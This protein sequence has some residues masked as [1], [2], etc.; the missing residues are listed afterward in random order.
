MVVARFGEGSDADLEEVVRYV[1]E[2]VEGMR[3]VPKVTEKVVYVSTGGS[4]SRQTS[5]YTAFGKIQKDGDVENKA[6]L[7]EL[8]GA[9]RIRDDLE[10]AAKTTE[11]LS[12]LADDRRESLFGEYDKVSDA[13]KAAKD[14]GL[15]GFA[16]T[17]FVWRNL[18]EAQKKAVE[19]WR[20]ESDA[21]KMP[22]GV[23]PASSM[24][25][26]GG[27]S[28][29]PMGVPLVPT[30]SSSGRKGGHNLIKSVFAAA[31]KADDATDPTR[32]MREKMRQL[33]SL[34]EYDKATTG[35]LMGI[36]AWAQMS[37]GRRA[38]WHTI[39]VSTDARKR[40]S[41]MPSLFSLLIETIDEI[42]EKHRR[43]S[44]SAMAAVAGAGTG[45]AGSMHVTRP[46]PMA[47]VAGARRSSSPVGRGSGEH[48]KVASVGVGAG[49]G[50]S[51]RVAPSA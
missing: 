38:E 8:V 4:G 3:P 42:I 39:Q 41:E 44:A 25:G 37:E 12:T 27:A 6:R 23:V 34:S 14:C 43:A 26:R 33:K 13:V 46:V 15:T 5:A 16:I 35:L 7:D 28:L 24:V 32:E 36:K 50:R 9:V 21:S 1:V 19:Q 48:H 40:A 31:L 51:L 20:N 47:A 17:A 49:V 10:Y 45:V 11:F 22:V 18:S 29:H 30:T 2:C